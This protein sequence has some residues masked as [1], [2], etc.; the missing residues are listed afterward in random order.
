M[1]IP[2]AIEML[3]D[4]IDFKLKA[5]ELMRNNVDGSTV[6]N[7]ARQSADLHDKEREKIEQILKE[8]E[9]ES[10]KTVKTKSAPTIRDMISEEVRIQVTQELKKLKVKHDTKRKKKSL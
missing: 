3:Q 1:T 2:R 10:K 7:L 9:P 5:A 4:F 6:G 8:L